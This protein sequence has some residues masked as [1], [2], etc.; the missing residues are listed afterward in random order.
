MFETQSGLDMESVGYQN[1]LFFDSC[2]KAYY[3]IFHDGIVAMFGTCLSGG[4]VCLGTTQ[5]SQQNIFIVTN[6]GL[7]DDSKA[8]WT[9]SILLCPL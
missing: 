8:Q 2:C 5:T 7:M 6:F 9:W 3:K 1:E 4:V